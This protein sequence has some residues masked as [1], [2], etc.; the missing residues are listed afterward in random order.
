MQTHSDMVTL[1]KL[2]TRLKIEGNRAE[3]DGTMLV[4][5]GPLALGAG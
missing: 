1:S 4:G 3:L 5:K 2:V